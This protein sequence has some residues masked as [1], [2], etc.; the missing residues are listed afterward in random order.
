MKEVLKHKFI[1]LSAFLKKLKSSNNLKAHLKTLGK[2][3]KQTHPK[4]V[5]VRK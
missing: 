3:E 2:K 1:A 4:E 5:D